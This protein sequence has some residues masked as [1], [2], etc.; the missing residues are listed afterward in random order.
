[1][2]K[3]IKLDEFNLD[4]TIH[5]NPNDWLSNAFFCLKLDDPRNE[6]NDNDKIASLMRALKGK[7]KESLFA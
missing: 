2:K 4:E 1:M 5:H 7:M 6:L 3:Q